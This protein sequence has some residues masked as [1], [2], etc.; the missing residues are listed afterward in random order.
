MA[1]VPRPCSLVVWVVLLTLAVAAGTIA[2]GRTAPGEAVASFA[3]VVAR[4]TRHQ[5][6]AAP[7]R[8]TAKAPAF[9]G[10]VAETA[11][12][13]KQ[14]S[15]DAGA[16]LGQIVAGTTVKLWA[17]NTDSTWYLVEA[18]DGL[19]GWMPAARLTID[20]GAA[21]RLPSSAPSRCNC[22]AHAGAD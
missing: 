19:I 10:V 2:L 16:I 5:G 6:I 11:S 4:F 9:T 12:V 8:E 3:T 20:P 14:T 15:A 18:P 22:G 13:R 1:I 17:R 7:G 21:T